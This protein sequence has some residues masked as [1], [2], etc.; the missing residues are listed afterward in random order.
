MNGSVLQK[1]GDD[2]VPMQMC[3]TLP[4]CQTEASCLSSG[5]VQSSSPAVQL[6]F[7]YCWRGQ[8][9]GRRELEED[10]EWAEPRLAPPLRTLHL[11]HLHWYFPSTA[12]FSLTKA[13]LI[14]SWLKCKPLRKMTQETSC[15]ISCTQWSYFTFQTYVNINTFFSQSFSGCCGCCGRQKRWGWLTL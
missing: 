15:Y 4:G 13:S 2:W 11:T 5:W 6:S 8:Q 9:H 3:N 14:S 12:W 7:S 1:P 10:S